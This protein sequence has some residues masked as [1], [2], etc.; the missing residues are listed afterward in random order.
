M[1]TIDNVR[2]E[3]GFQHGITI[4]SDGTIWYDCPVEVKTQE[5]L[6]HFGITWKNCKPFGYCVGMKMTVFYFKTTNLTYAK[7]QWLWLNREYCRKY[8]DQRCLIPG[9]RKAFIKCPATNHCSDCPYKDVRQA[10]VISLDRMIDETGYEPESAAPADEQAIARVIWQEVRTM[11]D[12]V[13]MRIAQVF[14]MQKLHGYSS[15]EIATKLGLPSKCV[16][17]LIA[18]ARKICKTYVENKK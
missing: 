3:T 11:M 1:T 8:R 12:A 15:K 9:R 17:Q 14:E 16:D 4:D 2:H 7:D 5:D 10:P 13:D 18:Q 6:D